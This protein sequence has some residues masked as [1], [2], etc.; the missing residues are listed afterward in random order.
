MDTITEIIRM[1]R[2][3]ASL[4]RRCLL[5]GATVMEMP[6]C[7]EGEA[8]F[9]VLVEGTCTLELPNRPIELRPGDV[10]LFPWS[11]PAHRIHTTGEGPAQEAVMTPGDNFA[12]FR[13]PAGEAAIDLF[14]GY[15]LYGAG[16]GTMFFRSLPNPLHISFAGSGNASEILRMLSTILRQEAEND[17]PGTAAVLSHLCSALLAMV[18][19]KTNRRFTETALWTAADDDRIR[20][21]IDAVLREPGA[22]WTIARLAQIVN[23]SRATF[24]RHFSQCTGMTVGALLAHIRLMTAADLL[25]DTDFPVAAVATEVGYRSESAF[26]RA[27]RLATGSTPARFRRNVANSQPTRML[28]AYGPPQLTGP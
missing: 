11:A 10:L 14:C 3:Q 6:A 16:A 23:M 19:R 8:P 26:S 21:V 28:R 27:F 4:D 25:T 15:Y 17:G 13:S 9:H 24:V 2:V 7:G 20:A 18:L 22:D 1:A 12:T 5:A